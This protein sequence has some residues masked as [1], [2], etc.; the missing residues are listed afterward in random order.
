MKRTQIQQ[1][2]RPT[3]GIITRVGF[4]SNLAKSV[5]RA[6]ADGI[7]D[8]IRASR[9]HH[10]PPCPECGTPLAPDNLGDDPGTERFECLN[11]HCNAPVWFR[12]DNGPLMDPSERNAAYRAA[13]DNG[14][15]PD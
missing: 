11:D 4:F 9:D 2:H 6:A 13:R 14:G 15:A 3:P 8:A 12:I 5:S 1:S 10:G 7:G